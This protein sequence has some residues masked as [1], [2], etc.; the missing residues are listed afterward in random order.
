MKKI[1]FL[2][3]ALFLIAAC[4]TAQPAPTS[5]PLPPTVPPPP[6]DTS[7]PPTQAPNPH[8]EEVLLGFAEAI[9]EKDLESAQEA[10]TEDARAKSAESTYEGKDE[11]DE[12]VGYEIEMHKSFFKFSEFVVEGDNVT[13]TWFINDQ[14]GKYLCTA[15]VTMQEDKISSIEMHECNEQ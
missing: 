9:N 6:T 2:L 12:W 3:T 14:T 7:I 13:F 15:N 1:L 5:T 8:A 11:V 4:T 10:F